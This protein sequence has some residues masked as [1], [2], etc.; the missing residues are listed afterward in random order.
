MKT[1]GRETV[2]EVKVEVTGD[3][4]NSWDVVAAIEAEKCEI[5]R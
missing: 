3:E 4:R 1:G 5:R 2:V